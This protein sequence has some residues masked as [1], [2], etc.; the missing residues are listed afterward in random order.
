MSRLRHDMTR[1]VLFL[2]RPFHLAI[3]DHPIAD[4]AMIRRVRE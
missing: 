2:T 1:S 3:P 4:R